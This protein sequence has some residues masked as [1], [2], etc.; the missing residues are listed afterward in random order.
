MATDIETGALLF[1]LAVLCRSPRPLRPRCN[2]S[3]VVDPYLSRPFACFVV[4]DK[5]DSPFV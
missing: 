5:R 3:V 4:E 1:P 2:Q